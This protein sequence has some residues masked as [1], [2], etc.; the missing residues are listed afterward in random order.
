MSKFSRP[1]WIPGNPNDRSV[2][3]FRIRNG[4]SKGPMSRA[5]YYA[6]KARGLGPREISLGLNRIII[7]AA[8]EAAWLEARAN[9]GDTEARLIAEIEAARKA[10][11]RKA[12][13]AAAASPRHVS[14][15]ARGSAEAA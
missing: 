1:Q 6:M 11:G 8:D 7:T 13:R 12:G 3:G 9:P 15:R 4:S 14:K 10:R 5:F 2:T